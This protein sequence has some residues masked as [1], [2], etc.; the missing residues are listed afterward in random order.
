VYKPLTVSTLA[1]NSVVEYAVKRC[2]FSCSVRNS[3]AVF[4]IAVGRTVKGSKGV[5]EEA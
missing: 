1:S 4:K 3:G 2:T 5:F